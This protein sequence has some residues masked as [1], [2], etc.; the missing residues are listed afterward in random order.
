MTILSYL[1]KMLII[2]PIFGKAN[3]QR[4]D[5][6]SMRK[7]MSFEELVQQNREQIMQDHSMLEQIE[8]NIVSRIHQSVKNI[9]EQSS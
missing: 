1:Q 7:G 4:S 8:E 9:H 5:D 6:S 3:K 2:R